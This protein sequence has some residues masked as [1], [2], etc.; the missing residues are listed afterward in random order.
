MKEEL[1]KELVANSKFT[2]RINSQYEHKIETLER[3][4]NHLRAEISRNQSST[5][6]KEPSSKNEA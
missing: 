1:I 4:C 5:S 3:E 2:N 6:A